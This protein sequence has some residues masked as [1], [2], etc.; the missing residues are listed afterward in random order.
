MAVSVVAAIAV[1]FWYA[2]RARDQARIWSR[3]LCQEQRVQLLDETVSLVKT[4]PRFDGNGLAFMRVFRFEFSEEGIGR[5]AGELVLVRGRLERAVLD[6][7]QIGRVIIAG[8]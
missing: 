5:S 4:R 8:H 1:W 6:G 2:M 3:R 7:Q